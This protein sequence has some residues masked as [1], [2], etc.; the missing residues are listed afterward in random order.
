M[1]MID[2][3]ETCSVWSEREHKAKKQHKCG[4]CS[5][6]I[7]AGETYVAIFG[8]F[9]G[10][11]FHGKICGHCAVLADWLGENCGGYLVGMVVEDF[12]EHARDY[13]RMDL[14]RLAVM[15]RKDWRS[16]RRRQM[17]PVPIVPRPLSPEARAA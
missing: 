13:R 12:T 1:C 10:D 4:E 7:E 15:A 6:Q 17:V 9:E 2:D 3:G 8:V 11:P 5:R 16:V 14:A